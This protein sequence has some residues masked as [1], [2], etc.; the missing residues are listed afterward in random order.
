[1][2]EAATDRLDA[3]ALDYFTEYQKAWILDESPMKLIEKSRRIGL[4]YATSFRRVVKAMR[5]ANLDCW[6]STRD[7][8]TAREFVRECARWVRLAN[9][10]NVAVSDVQVEVADAI[11]TRKAVHAQLISFPNGSRI[12][13][14]TSNP[15]ALAGKGGDIVLD[16]FALHKDQELLWQVALPTASVWGFQI[17]I[18]STHRGKRTLFNKFCQDA[19]RANR[20]GWSH[21]KVTIKDACDGGLVE[22]I[23]TATARRGIAPITAAAFIATQRDRCSTQ[24]QFDQ[25]YMCIPGDDLGAL[26]PYHLI[27]AC[28]RPAEELERALDAEPLGPRFLGMDVARRKHKSVIWVAED[29]ALQL[30]TLAVVTMEDRKLREQC[31]TLCEVW[32]QWRCAGGAIDS[33]GI[34]IQIA[35]DAQDRLG[36]TLEAVVFTAASQNQMANLMV[37]GFQDQAVLIP[38]SR[39]I[40]EAL[41]KV[42]K[43]VTAHGH[44]TYVAPEDEAGHADE[45]WALAL[46]MRAARSGS[47]PAR[48][49]RVGAD[50]ADPLAAALARMSRP[51]HRGDTAARG[52]QTQLL[53]AAGARG[54]TREF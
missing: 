19:S 15:D 40:E 3:I 29:V 48:A 5:I 34:G 43:A 37:Q 17:E 49:M 8:I 18:I 47:G 1:M 7:L 50:D 25:E 45:F 51:D 23:N 32:R 30:R 13:V 38:D 31:D 21:H 22:R 41:H 36:S 6:V 12:Y 10:V 9:L 54:I 52:A 35:E 24:A 11:D 42:E 4:T 2:P 14:L 26:L 20:M 28:Q 53:E 44:I 33:T 27:A 39:E 46:C 16:E